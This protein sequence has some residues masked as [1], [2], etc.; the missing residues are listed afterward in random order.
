MSAPHVTVIAE[1]GVNHNGRLDLALVM[2]DAAVAA[3]AVY[4]QTNENCG[5]EA[6]PERAMNLEPP[7]ERRTPIRSVRSGA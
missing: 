7:Q 6:A 5:K 4:H 3:R 1:A 2:A